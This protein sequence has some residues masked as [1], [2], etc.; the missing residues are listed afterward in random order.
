MQPPMLSRMSVLVSTLS[1]V[2][3]PEGTCVACCPFCKSHTDE[4]AFRNLRQGTS[5]HCCMVY[6]KSILHAYRG[7]AQCRTWAAAKVWASVLTL[8]QHSCY[9]HDNPAACM[10]TLTASQSA[11]MVYG[12]TLLVKACRVNILRISGTDLLWRD[13]RH[14]AAAVVPR[15]ILQPDEGVD[16]VAEEGREG[17][18]MQEPD[19]RTDSQL[20]Q[21]HPCAQ[22]TQEFQRWHL[23]CKAWSRQAIRLPADGP[24][25]QGPKAGKSTSSTVI[26]GAQ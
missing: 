9:L 12:V 21:S 2:S 20:R 17:D 23:L 15:S 7:T 6:A 19:L 26:M 22:R 14:E 13:S 1:Q 25:L 16:G 4:T 8:Q 5:S 11:S 18:A 24:S 10:Q 3:R